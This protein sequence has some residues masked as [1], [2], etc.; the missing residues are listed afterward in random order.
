MASLSVHGPMEI[1]SWLSHK[2]VCKNLEGNFNSRDLVKRLVLSESG[3]HGGKSCV[4]STLY[5]RLADM[6]LTLNPQTLS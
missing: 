3:L 4:V 1:L 5:G 6:I 2:G